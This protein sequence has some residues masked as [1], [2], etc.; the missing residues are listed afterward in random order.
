MI[1]TVDSDVLVLAIAAVQHLRIKE[2][3]VA[4]ATG[5]NI[6]YLPAHEMATALGPEKSRP[7]PYKLAAGVIL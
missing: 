6:R 1:R 2:L 4:F 7:L 5:K 3:W